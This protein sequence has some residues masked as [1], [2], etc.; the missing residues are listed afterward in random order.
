MNLE[1]KK[2]LIIIVLA[3]AAGIAATVMTGTYVK[4]KIQEETA[5]LAKQFSKQQEQK[6]GEIR[7]ISD[8]Q[9]AFF[10]DK[11][12]QLE[13]EISQTKQNIAARPTQ[14][15]VETAKPKKSSLT[16]KLPAGK[17]AVTLTFNSL[18]AVGGFVNPGD[19][20][21]VIAQLNVPASSDEGASTK[22]DAVTI[23]LFQNLKILAVNNNLDDAGDPDPQQ[24][25]DSGALRI[26]FAVDP[27]EA[28]LISFASKNGNLELALRSPSEKKNQILQASTW[29]TLADYV[30]TNT[31]TT[32]TVP[33][34]EKTGKGT[35]V[36]TEDDNEEAK[37]YIQIFRAGQEL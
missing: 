34:E 5:V 32:L 9:A 35:D 17:R 13:G 18:S 7:Q 33:E 22:K 10:R 37:P 1:N 31:G 24:R 25:Q 19:F 6:Y 12:S 2:Q 21:D 3:V 4:N 26:T 8:Q 20:V 11:I 15:Q 36:K 30:L 14:A 23:M 27:Q 29:K 28:G 16:E